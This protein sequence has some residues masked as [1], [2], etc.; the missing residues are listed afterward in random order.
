LGGTGDEHTDISYSFGQTAVDSEGNIVVAGRTDSTDFP[1]KDAYQDTFGGTS[2]GTISKYYPNGTLIFSTYFG[3][4]GQEQI[5]DLAIDSDDNIIVGGTTGSSNLPV[6][7]ALKSN[8]T[9]VNEGSVDGFLAKFSDDGQT[10]LYCTYFGG[11]G[12]DYL[13]TLNIDPS[14]RIAVSGTTDST[15]FPLLNPHQDTFVNGL[16]VFVS[17]I[18]TDGLTLMFSTYIGTTGID[19][20][21]RVAFDST[22]NVLVTGIC[23]IGDLATDGAYQ[24]EHAGGTTDAFLAKFSTTGNLEYLTFL[25]GEATDW[26]NDLAIDSDDNVVITGFTTSDEFPTSNAYQDSRIAYADMFISKV[27]PS[28]ENL[29]FSTYLGGSSPDYGN[30]V[31]IDDYNRI[32][33]I[34]QTESLDFPRNITLGT[35]DSSHDNMSLTVF[36]PEGSLIFSMIC[37]GEDDDVGI[38]ITSYSDTSYIVIGYTESSDFPTREAFQE[39]YAGD[40]DM[41]LMKLDLEDFIDIPVTDSSTTTTS[42]TDQFP[43]DLLMSGIAIGAIVVVILLVVVRKRSG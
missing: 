23:G 11:S 35:A 25:G 9:G 34:G 7:N 40:G 16:D 38:G 27:S 8:S 21:R 31:M 29:V 17:L 42:D 12:N 36:D 30:A 1:L 24:E 20:G 32:F 43:T 37:G 28:G 39:N 33:I 4:I 19:H 15:D 22:G 5:T 3:G 26:G 41:F 14:G 10:L 2:D 18:D 13:Y 6:V